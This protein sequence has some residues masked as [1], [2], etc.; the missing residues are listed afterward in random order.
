MFYQLFFIKGG[1]FCDFL[2]GSLVK[3]ALLK[4]N[5]LLCILS[6]SKELDLDG[7][8]FFLYELTPIHKIMESKQENGHCF[9]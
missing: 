5:L 6:K 7:K 8:I 2:F 9:P 3:K 4:W 1:N